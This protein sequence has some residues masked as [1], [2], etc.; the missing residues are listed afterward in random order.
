M[1]N[2]QGDVKGGQVEAVKE[3]ILAEQEMIILCLRKMI[4]FNHY[5]TWQGIAKED[6]VTTVRSKALSR[7]YDISSS[8]AQLALQYL[9]DAQPVHDTLTDQGTTYTVYDIFFKRYLKRRA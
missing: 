5:K 9:V 1:S 2:Y 7:S 8:T 4:T 6:C 3:K